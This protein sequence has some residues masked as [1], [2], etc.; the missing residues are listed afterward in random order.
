M[1]TKMKTCST[2]C[3]NFKDTSD[4]YPVCIEDQDIDWFYKHPFDCPMFNPKRSRKI[5]HNPHGKT[6]INKKHITKAVK[7]P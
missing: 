5:K 4:R 7:K 1:V 3:K 2:H 6:S